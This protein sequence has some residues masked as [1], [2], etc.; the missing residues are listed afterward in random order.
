M[1]CPQ[2]EQYIIEGGIILIK[3]WLEVGMEEQEAAASMRGS[4]IRCG[5]GS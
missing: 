3:L 4:T 2:M 1:L 5:S